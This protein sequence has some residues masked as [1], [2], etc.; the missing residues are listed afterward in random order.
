MLINIMS[1]YYV[2]LPHP[3]LRMT[4]V[5]E[6]S[7]WGAEELSGVSMGSTT[8]QPVGDRNTI[9]WCHITL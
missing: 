2:L 8:E 7:C 4:L 6:G 1:F 9:S 5:G 3:H